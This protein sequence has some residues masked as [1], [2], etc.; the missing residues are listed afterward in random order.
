MVDQSLSLHC[1]VTKTCGSLRVLSPANAMH[2]EGPRGGTIESEADADAA[3]LRFVREFHERLV[4]ILDVPTRSW[5]ALMFSCLAS[6][7]YL[8]ARFADLAFRSARVQVL[9]VAHRLALRAGSERIAARQL[10][11]RRSVDGRGPYSLQPS[12]GALRTVDSRPSSGISCPT[13]LLWLAHLCFRT[14]GLC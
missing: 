5:L 13:H 8:F 9:A 1:H 11:G 14:V 10:P 3:H 4:S 6:R 7:V 2:L 12:R